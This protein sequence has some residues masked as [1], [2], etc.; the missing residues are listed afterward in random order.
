MK[1]DFDIQAWAARYAQA[2]TL[3]TEQPHPLTCELSN[4]AQHD[5]PQ[6]V[7]LWRD[8]DITA[9]H[10][11]AARQQSLQPL[12]QHI[13]TAGRVILLGCGSSGRL[14]YWIANWAQKSN[15]H[16]LVAG[17]TAALVQSQEGL[18]DS[19]QAGARALSAFT[20][21]PQDV[22]IGLAASG[23]TPFVL[24]A[25]Q[26][27]QRQAASTWLITNNAD[28]LI[29]PQLPDPS[30]LDGV[31]LLCLDV[32]PMALT[33]STRLQATTAMQVA[34]VQL[35]DLHY[36]TQD[37]I[38]YLQQLEWTALV[39]TV[40]WEA[41]ALNQTPI[42]YVSDAACLLTTL[43]DIT[44]RAPTFNVPALSQPNTLWQVST[45]DQAMLN[46]CAGFI[47]PRRTDLPA[48]QITTSGWLLDHQ[49]V[50]T[51]PSAPDAILQVGLKC[52]LNCHST[53]VMGRRGYYQGN[54]MTHLS[55]SNAKLI[56]RA[57]RYVLA[58]DDERDYA[59][60]AKQALALPT[61]ER[62]MSLVQCLLNKN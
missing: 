40:D 25:L 38:A 7:K 11:L 15:V 49:P 10:K 12:Q 31:N 13:D 32:G 62:G 56:D 18:E 14:A 29:R 51:L 22:V 47:S 26:A 33:G 60:V 46:R 21:Q 41:R 45:D 23:R 24:G 36:T 39:K 59:T 27:A 28:T 9:L 8:I 19:A 53:L 43:A 57:I 1:V 58:L 35:F 6:A 61:L 4:L 44:E 30:L 3:V 54:L 55:P 2:P 20:P 34:L 17:G 37:F 5:L 48:L 16:A 52:L 42:Q 50:L